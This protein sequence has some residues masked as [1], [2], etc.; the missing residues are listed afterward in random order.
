M[1]PECLVECLDGRSDYYY[2]IGQ[3][4][5]TVRERGA[6]IVRVYGVSEG[7]LT[8]DAGTRG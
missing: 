4:V 3:D 2:V 1:A 6:R 7:V 5:Q 8:R